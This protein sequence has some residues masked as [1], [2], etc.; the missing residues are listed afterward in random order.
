MHSRQAAYT[1]SIGFGFTWPEIQPGFIHHTQ[2]K[3]VNHY[4][5]ET[6][7]DVDIRVLKWTNEQSLTCNACSLC[8]KEV[9][10]TMTF[11]CSKYVLVW[12]NISNFQ[13]SNP[14]QKFETFP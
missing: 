1:N 4:T 8:Y 13:T 12:K 11:S 9:K 7:V 3:H 10:I 6:V 5:T 2:S 14:F